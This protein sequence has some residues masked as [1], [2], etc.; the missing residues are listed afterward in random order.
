MYSYT[1]KDPF[2]DDIRPYRDSEV[3]GVLQSFIHSPGFENSI[4][5]ML[6]QYISFYGEEEKKII[7]RNFRETLARI[8]TVEDFQKQIVLKFMLEPVVRNTIDS[9][10]VSGLEK[11]EKDKGYLFIGN[12]RDI[13]LDPAL[14]NYLLDKNGFHSA[15]I[16]F[17]NNLLINEVI[18]AMIRLNKS[19]IV[20]RNLPLMKQLEESKHLSEYIFHTMEQNRSVWI[21]QREGRAKDGNDIT[22]PAVIT[23]LHLSQRDRLPLPDYIK[24]V[25]L[26]PVAVSY[27]FD[28]CDRLKALEILK[29]RNSGD[30]AK[31]ASDDLAS[32]NRG[33]TGQKGRVHYSVA[34]SFDV[35]GATEKEIAKAV[36]RAINLSYHLWPVNYLAFDMHNSTSD[37][38]TF[39]SSGDEEKFNERIKRLSPEVRA[40]VIE[41][42]ANPVRNYEIQNR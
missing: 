11:L 15:E 39:Y 25:N 33:I 1:E 29:A 19:F 18:T 31:S 2:F 37:Y 30:Q 10:T 42:Y 14:L 38:S 22:N 26:T 9:L 21:A 17:G 32:M 20:K 16:A 35:T 5:L 3:E 34:E 28:P 23:M 24:K 12:H 36:D 6:G 4:N 40:I 13:T 7:L 8:K 27:E 41:G